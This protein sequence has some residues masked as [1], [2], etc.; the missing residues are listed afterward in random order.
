ME[1]MQWPV[2]VSN[3]WVLHNQVDA[4]LISLLKEVVCTVPG[5]GE[6]AGQ[7]GHIKVVSRALTGLWAPM[8]L[9]FLVALLV[10]IIVLFLLYFGVLFLV[11]VA[12]TVG[13]LMYLGYLDSHLLH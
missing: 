11:L 13:F 12:L 1:Q 8:D 3:P 10:S 9:G 5:Q 6:G 4:V 2:V 7:Q